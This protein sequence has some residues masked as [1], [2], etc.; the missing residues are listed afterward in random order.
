M[1]L[2]VG[3]N[4]GHW[5]GLEQPLGHHNNSLWWHG[6]DAFVVGILWWVR[7]TIKANGFPLTSHK[8][9]ME[10]MKLREVCAV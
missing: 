5:Y 6:A 7:Y 3:Y 9:V 1:V 4:D 8:K 10:Q 2:V